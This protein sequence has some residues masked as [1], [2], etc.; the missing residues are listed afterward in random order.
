MPIVVWCNADTV[1]IDYKGCCCETFIFKKT[2][3]SMLKIVPELSNLNR[4][5]N[6]FVSFNIRAHASISAIE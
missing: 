2:L 1:R 5:I 4:G 6:V 3:I